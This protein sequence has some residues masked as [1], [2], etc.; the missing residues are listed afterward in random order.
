MAHGIAG[1]LQRHLAYHE[2]VLTIARRDLTVRYKQTYMGIAWALL[3]PLLHM[4]VFTVIFTRV[5]PLRTDLPYPIYAYAGL[6]PWTLFASSLR[7]ATTSLTDNAA[8]VTKV[9]FPRE[10]FPLA[11]VLVALVDFAVASTV[12]AALMAWYR[13]PPPP[14][15]LLLPVVL[16]VQ[17]AFT[18][19]LALLLS[20][21]NLFYRDVKHLFDVVIVVWMFTTSVVY[22]VDAVG[23]RVGAVLRANPMTPIID[24]YRAVLLRGELPP[25]GTFAYAAGVAAATLWIG[26]AAFRRLEFRFAEDI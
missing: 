17:L 13:V 22:P 9:Y 25:A 24:A 8:L 15:A 16:V 21:A 12:L 1:A 23:G 3:T 18:A 6:L 11:T 5:V 19:G 14:T 20:T 26:W 7:F 4:A 2:L 10:A